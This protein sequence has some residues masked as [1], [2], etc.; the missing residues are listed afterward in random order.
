MK[1]I[2]LGMMIAAVSVF[3]QQSTYEK[4]E[5]AAKTQQKMLHEMESQSLLQATNTYSL[6]QIASALVEIANLEQQRVNLQKCALV[7]ARYGASSK[8][9]LKYCNSLDKE[10]SELNKKHD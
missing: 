5:P 7:N 3:A 6:Q 1:N 9:T 10:S 4:N 8:I 2:I